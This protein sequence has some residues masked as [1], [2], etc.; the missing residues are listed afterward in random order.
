MASAMT[1]ASASGQTGPQPNRKA[2][3]IGLQLLTLVLAVAA[4]GLP[5]NDIAVYAMLVAAAVVV[6]TGIVRVTPQAWGAAAAIVVVGIGAQAVFAPPRIDEGFNVFLPGGALE[7]DLPADVYRHMAAEFDKQYPADKRCDA[8][9][10]GCWRNSGAPDRAFAFA[11]DGIFHPFDLSRAVT[12]FNLSDPVWHRFGF[13]NDMRFNWYPISDV[14]RA[15]RDGRFWKG[16]DRWQL[17][18]PW[19]AMIRLPAAYVGG[20]LCWRGDILWEGE[21]ESFTSV[22]QKDGGCRTIAPD[23]A[24]RR[25]VGIAIRPGTLAMHLQGPPA[26]TL[27]QWMQPLIKLITVVALIVVLVQIK[28]RRAAIPLILTGLAA[29]VIAIDDASFLGGVRPFDGG[30]DGIFYDSMGRSILQKLLA[31][32]W[33]GFLEGGEK[34]FYYGGPGLRYFRALEH[35][36][37]GDS[38]LGYLSIVLML[39]LIVLALFRRFLSAPSPSFWPLVLALLFV[40]VPIGTVFG[41]SFIDYSKWAARGFAD[42]MAY[43]LFLAGLVPLL[44]AKESGPRDAFRPAFFGA[45]LIVVGVAMKPI[46]VVAA[47]VLLGGAWC[48]AAVGRRWRR[49]AG[50]SLGALPVLSMA[51]HNWVFGRA[52]VLFSANSQDSNL[53]VMPPSVWAGALREVVTFDF[54][55]GLAHRALMQIPNWLSGPAESYWTAP[56]NAAGVAILLY[57]VLRGRDFDPWLRLI[58]GAALA[59]HAVALFYATTARYHFLTWF[60]TLLVAAAF[61]QQAGLPWLDRRYPAL[62]ARLTRRLWPPRLAAGVAWLEGR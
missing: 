8:N 37:F 1:D 51:L 14:Q 60:L 46:I 41:T 47:F 9:V 54:G 7:R 12:S 39:P 16:Y 42:P 50:L 56:L 48:W 40:A 57:V 22:E 49:L 23:D 5:V 53:L 38:Y 33:I 32:D 25:V 31:G 34:V 61:M 18:M 62:M 11:A 26:V 44:G 13:I 55:G 4:A 45:L 10:P 36:A 30:D 21:G 59:Q 15:R 20:K 28:P 17:T 19:F 3:Q 52:F 2:R 43:I 35:I 29:L 58:G 27:K 6:L 24:A